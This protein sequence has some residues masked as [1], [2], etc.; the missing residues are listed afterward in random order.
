MWLIS[1]PYLQQA[2]SR[3]PEPV[4]SGT[5]I[6][7]GPCFWT[8]VGGIISVLALIFWMV[9]FEPHGGVELSMY[10]FPGSSW[11]FG[12]SYQHENVPVLLWYACALLHWTLV[13]AGIDVVRLLRRR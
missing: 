6:H 4:L 10:L 9:T 12:L 5:V 7:P 3:E 13:G 1:S 8:A 2:G 11:L